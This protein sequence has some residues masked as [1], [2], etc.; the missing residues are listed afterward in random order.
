MIKVD[1]KVLQ[2]FLSRQW[3]TKLLE[4]GVDMTDAKYFLGTIH[5]EE[6]IAYKKDEDCLIL[7]DKVPTYTVS[8]LLY[9][10]WE[11]ICPIIDGRQYQGGLRMIK[12]APFYIFY[13]DLHLID[14]DSV[15]DE[16]IMGNYEYPIE[17]LASLLIQCHKRDIGLDRKDT[18][19]ISS[20]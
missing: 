18:G 13:Y 1:K 11:W 20:K 17:S 8:E 3:V 4:S 6:Y 14:D 9:K 5:D 10:L 19:N 15:F 12:D 2:D 16:S 7:F